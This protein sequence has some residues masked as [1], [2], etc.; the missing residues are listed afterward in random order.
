MQPTPIY[1]T[2]GKMIDQRYNKI[3]Q[4]SSV[5]RAGAQAESELLVWNLFHQEDTT[6]NEEQHNHTSEGNTAEIKL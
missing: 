4:R 3:W 5:T 2:N 1:S 6:T